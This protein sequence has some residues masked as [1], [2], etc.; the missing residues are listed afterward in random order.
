MYISIFTFYIVSWLANDRFNFILYNLWNSE[1]MSVIKLNNN[2]LVRIA[3]EKITATFEFRRWKS[4]IITILGFQYMYTTYYV[5]KSIARQA[6]V[7]E[8]DVTWN[9]ETIFN[10]KL[11]LKHYKSTVQQSHIQST[12]KHTW[13]RISHVSI[14]NLNHTH[15]T[16]LFLKCSVLNRMKFLRFIS[17]QWFPSKSFEHW[18]FLIFFLTRNWIYFFYWPNRND[19]VCGLVKSLFNGVSLYHFVF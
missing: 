5:S 12:H 6:M 11:K 18:M 8:Q 17:K 3:F 10:S 1:K 7:D 16:Y 14:Y 9:I 2:S 19:Y 4:Y 15:Q 13:T